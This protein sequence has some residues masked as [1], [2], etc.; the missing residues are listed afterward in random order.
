MIL[1]SYYRAAALALLAALSI[2]GCGG[3]GKSNQNATA[4]P[5]T[6][7]QRENAALPTSQM[8]PI[9]KNVHCGAV[10][11]VWVNL[12]T[13]AYHE[14]ADPY[15]GRTK[16]G[17]YLCPNQAQAQGF[18]PAGARHHRRRNRGGA[19]MNNQGGASPAASPSY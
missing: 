5:T 2:A 15:Y 4:A 17:E 7:A 9:P 18:H 11:P 8:A 10:K 13:K 19:M 12:H 16:S 6:E 1:P 14:P 3:G